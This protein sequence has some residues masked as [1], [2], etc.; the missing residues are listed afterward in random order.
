VVVLARVLVRAVPALA[1]VGV[2]DIEDIS[3]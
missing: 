3:L 2:G 1:L